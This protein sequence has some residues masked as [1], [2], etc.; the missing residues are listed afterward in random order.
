MTKQM[1]LAAYFNPTGHHVASWRHPRAQRDAHQNI[2]HYVE[3]ARTAERA[4][5]DMIFLAD[6]NATRDAD[7]EAI[8]RSVQFVAHF[9]PITLLSAL[10][11]VT[12]NIGLTA[13]ASTTYNE[14]YN[15]ARKFASLDHISHGR[16]GWNLV[17][18]GQPAEAAN[19]GRD[20]VKEHS[21]RYSRAREFAEVVQGL[22]DSW[23]DDAF[24]RDT[25]SGLFFEPD[26][27]HHLN[28]KGEHFKVR[29]PLNVPRPP[30]GY[31]VMVQA[32]ASDEGRELAAQYAEAIFSP[33]LN[34]PAAKAYYDDVK[35]RMKAYN[36]DPDHLKV[37]PGISVVV[38]ESDDKAAEDFNTLQSLIHPIV[39]R[40]I[41]STMLG[42]ADLT[43]YPLDEPLPDLP[44]TN[45][46]RGHFE[47][48]MAMARAENLTIRQLGERCAGARGKN[49]IHGSVKK[50][51]DYMEEWFA[52]NACDG[53]CVMPP[54]I[55]GQHDDFCNMVIPELQKR[56]L[57]RKEYEGATLRE[58]LGLPRPPSR[59]RG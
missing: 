17:T 38:A 12:K 11:M 16:S 27:M 37:L 34:I 21:E 25:K 41:L 55:S 5:F 58:N 35:G 59:H 49:S 45:A 46:S 57:F 54:Y 7:I 23:D 2:E 28:H 31:P 19:F 29:G 56:G 40:E 24:I 47:S 48:I 20:G 50:V 18:S 9:E 4:K 42:G 8:S 36:R 51:A 33:H 43:P 3:I 30:Q 14:P 15:L 32:G 22:W 26:R 52:A 13:T 1:K 39:G 53:F 44:L 6:G 10:A